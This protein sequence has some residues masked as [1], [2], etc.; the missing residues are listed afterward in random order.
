MQVHRS[1]VNGVNIQINSNVWQKFNVSR[2][3]KCKNIAID[4]VLYSA[5]LICLDIK[6][7]N[8]GKD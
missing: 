4:T 2:P 7:L 5:D 6:G 1:D 8:E 3:Q